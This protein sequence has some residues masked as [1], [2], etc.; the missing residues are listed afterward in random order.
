MAGGFHDDGDDDSTEVTHLAPAAKAP[1]VGSTAGGA[2]CFVTLTGQNIGEVFQLNQIELVIGRAA[3]SAIRCRDNG[4]SR[5]HARVATRDHR[6]TVEDLASAN[7][8]LVN[9]ERITSICEL[10][11][12]D[13][14][15]V[16]P[17]I[18]FRFT[19]DAVEES[20][21]RLMYDAALRDG[22]T[23]TFNKK[24]LLS[25]ID[26]EVAYA[27]RHDINL[28]LVI[29]D[30]DQF[31]SVNDSFGHLAGDVVLVKLAK[32]AIA[33]IR[34]EDVFA[35]YGGDE[36]AILCR[37]VPRDGAAVLAERLRLAVEQTVFDHDRKRLPVTISLGVAGAPNNTFKESAE[38]IAAA[39]EA[40]YGAKRAGRN[41]VFRAGN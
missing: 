18:V 7:G 34:T 30:V 3:G 36:F 41:R 35:R 20:F 26:T 10:R 13:K 5:R 23:K 31:K 24:Y 32:V 2:P 19:R 38:L 17:H 12:G 40:L 37:G 29:F 11:E 16:G 4:V 1:I 6:V 39:D 33:S 27:K 15:Q 21:Q 9:G 25:R 8:T 14:V 22:L 28:S